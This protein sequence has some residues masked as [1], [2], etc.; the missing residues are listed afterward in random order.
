[1]G[2]L[3]RVLGKGAGRGEKDAGPAAAPGDA[4]TTAAPDPA[5][6]DAPGEPLL[7]SLR[8]APGLYLVNVDGHT[9]KVLVK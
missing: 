3:S 6:D 1:M 9:T 2:L 5:D 7:P 4:A 8:V